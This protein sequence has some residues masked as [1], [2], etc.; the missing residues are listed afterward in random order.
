MLDGGNDYVRSYADQPHKDLSKVYDLL[1]VDIDGEVGKDFSNLYYISYAYL[2]G[3]LALKN[4]AVEKLPLDLQTN[5]NNNTGGAYTVYYDTKNSINLI[6]KTLYLF[7][8]LENT[9]DSDKEIIK[10]RFV[11]EK[12]R[13]LNYFK[14]IYEILYDEFTFMEPQDGK[15]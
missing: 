11:E 4:L 2:K 10:E 13:V 15:N 6:S 3:F 5:L 7:E 8:K 14:R 9:P 12:L 1:E